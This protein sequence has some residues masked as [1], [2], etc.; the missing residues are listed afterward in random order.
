MFET[1]HSAPYVGRLCPKAPT[2]EDVH[3]FCYAGDLSEGPWE[4]VAVCKWCGITPNG[5]R[6]TPSP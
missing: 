4:S 6:T 2:R 1:T 5:E 3:I